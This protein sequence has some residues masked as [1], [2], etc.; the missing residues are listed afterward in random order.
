MAY[1]ASNFLCVDPYAPFVA[2]LALKKCSLP[3]HVA[4][5]RGIA[6]NWLVNLAVYMATCAKYAVVIITAISANR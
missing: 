4:F 3:F 6:A 2:K 1:C 5:T